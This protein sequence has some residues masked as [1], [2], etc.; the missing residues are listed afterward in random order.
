MQPV[1]I[2][3]PASKAASSTTTWHTL[4]QQ[5]AL[6]L[7]FTCLYCQMHVRLA[8]DAFAARVHALIILMRIQRVH[9]NKNTC[10][11]K[12]VYLRSCSTVRLQHQEL[13]DAALP[14][15]FIVTPKQL[16]QRLPIA[17]PQIAQRSV[18]PFLQAAGVCMDRL[19]ENKG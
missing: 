10:N 15:R 18:G 6:M 9:S 17:V 3:S 2:A 5:T 7:E 8:P 11:I 19:Q 12:K 4:Q 14:A 13:E 16:H 1:R